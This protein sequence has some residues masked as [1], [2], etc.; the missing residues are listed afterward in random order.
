MAAGSPLLG[1]QGC[2]VRIKGILMNPTSMMTQ[3]LYMCRVTASIWRYWRYICR[4]M[5]DNT[6]AAAFDCQILTGSQR[7]IASSICTELVQLQ[8]LTDFESG[9]YLLPGCRARL[10][11]RQQCCSYAKLT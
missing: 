10:F 11:N 6:H 4:V 5:H 8:R 3:G 7:V 9:V 1:M 2:T